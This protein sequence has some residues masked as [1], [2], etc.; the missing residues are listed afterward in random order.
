[1][2]SL[3]IVLLLTYAAYSR[4]EFW[5]QD[6]LGI[7][8]NIVKKSPMKFRPHYNLS[9]E[10]DKRQRFAEAERELLT[11]ISL[12]PDNARAHNN[13]ARIYGKQNRIE[14]GIEELKIAIRLDPNYYLALRNLQ[15]GYESLGEFDKAEMARKK[16]DAIYHYEQGRL[17]AKQGLLRDAIRELQISIILNPDND[18]ANRE[19]GVLRGEGNIGSDVEQ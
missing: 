13:L 9:K 7:W 15:A 17:L 14:E 2:I 12:E 10:Y 8:E 5:Q 1:M 4:N 18:A 16:A 6:E 3:V 19:L 11:A